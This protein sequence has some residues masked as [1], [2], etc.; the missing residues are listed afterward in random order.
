MQVE[1][2]IPKFKQ[3]DCYFV[4][5]ST[6]SQNVL[7]SS[8]LTSFLKSFIGVRGVQGLMVS[9]EPIIYLLIP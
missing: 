5:I 9:S 8:S 1:I 3:T 2:L 7:S 6:Q 4:L